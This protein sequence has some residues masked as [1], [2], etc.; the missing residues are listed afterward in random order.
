M[1]KKPLK[2]TDKRRQAAHKGKSGVREPE[3]G[4]G[5]G[6]PLA[7]LFN[8]RRKPNGRGKKAF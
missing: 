2:A 5:E 7:S 3:S 8:E 4:S 6:S 1:S